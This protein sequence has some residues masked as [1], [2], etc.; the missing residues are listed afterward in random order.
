M[1][2]FKQPN[3]ESKYFFEISNSV[4]KFSLEK[5]TESDFSKNVPRGPKWV[6]FSPFWA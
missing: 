6:T 3:S 4:V 2:A 1:Y 5:V